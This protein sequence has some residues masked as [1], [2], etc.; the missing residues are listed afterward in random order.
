VVY[1]KTTDKIN[2]DLILQ[3]HSSKH[4]QCNYWGSIL[5]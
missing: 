3:M 4:L 2:E 5:W 1:W